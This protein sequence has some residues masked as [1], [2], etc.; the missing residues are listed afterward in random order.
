MLA[1]NERDIDSGFGELI[2]YNNVVSHHGP[3]PGCEQK[4]WTGLHLP[5]SL[6]KITYHSYHRTYA[7]H[8]SMFAELTINSIDLFAG[9]ERA[10][11]L[12]SAFPAVRTKVILCPA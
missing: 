9:R 8:F 1:A 10:C 6:A 5:G 7:V 12:Y 2:I 11:A 4:G 3:I